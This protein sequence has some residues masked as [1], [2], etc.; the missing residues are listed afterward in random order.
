MK[1]SLVVTQSLI[2]HYFQE[3]VIFVSDGGK[4][5]QY[6]QV[7]TEFGALRQSE[8]SLN[9]SNMFQPY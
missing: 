2:D 9:I 7:K 4:K 3:V 8:S 5:L 6:C 1:I